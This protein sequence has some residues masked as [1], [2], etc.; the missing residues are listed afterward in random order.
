MARPSYGERDPQ[1]WAM[2][3]SM[4]ISAGQANRFGLIHMLGNVQEWVMDG[5]ELRVLGGSYTDPIGECSAS[6]ARIHDGHAASDTG[7]R[8]VRE[9]S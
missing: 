4:K 7:F 3:R 2:Q 1:A 5:G 9:L 8:L 6:T